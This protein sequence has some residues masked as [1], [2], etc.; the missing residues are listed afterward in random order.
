MSVTTPPVARLQLGQLLRELREKAGRT[1][2]DAAITLECKKPKVSKIETGKAT[3]GPGDARLLIELYDTHGDT[4]D[5]VLRL[6]REARKRSPLRVPDWAQRFIALE[7]IS[8]SIRTYEN[9]LVPGL[10]QTEDYTRAVIKAAAHPERDTAAL[11]RIVAVRADRQARLTDENPPQVYAVINEA[12]IRRVVGG[13]R[14][15]H[16]QLVK[17]RELTEMPHVT[18]QILP[19]SAGAHVAM[20]SSFRVL[21]LAEPAGARVIYVEDL[22]TADYLDGPSQISRYSLVFDRLQI[23]APSEAETTALLDQAI[24]ESRA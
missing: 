14:I 20:G 19:F 11:E 18:L 16:E 5:T 22:M 1:Q 3:L 23:A 24:R 4:A 9:E 8:T 13:S 10:F 15:M 6:A 7:S 2:E 12:V 17:L 21:Q